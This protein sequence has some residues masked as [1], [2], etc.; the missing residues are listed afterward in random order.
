MRAPTRAF[1]VCALILAVLMG[2]ASCRMLKQSVATATAA[3]S[4]TSSGGNAS[5]VSLAQAI[6]SGGAAS[7]S[8]LA[9]AIS[10]GEGEAVAQSLAQVRKLKVSADLPLLANER[11]PIWR[12]RTKQ[13]DPRGRWCYQLQEELMVA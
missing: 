8:S 10:S 9:Q 1:A 11:P 3:A 4:A 6:S 7:A 12:R 5:A 2:S 13:I